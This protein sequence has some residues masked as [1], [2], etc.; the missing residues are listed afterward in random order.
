MDTINYQHE[1]LSAAEVV[2]KL[3]LYNC[4]V[5]FHIVHT[6]LI[7]HGYIAH[8]CDNMGSQHYKIVTVT[9]YCLHV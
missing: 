6:L 4:R 5:L 2:I 8:V 3:V 9:M 1:Y 7:F